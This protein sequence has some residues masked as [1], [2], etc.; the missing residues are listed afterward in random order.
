MATLRMYKLP[1]PAPTCCYR[2]YSGHAEPVAKSC[3]LSD[4]TAVSVGRGD[5]AII[6]WKVKADE[7][8]DATLSAMD[9]RNGSSAGFDWVSP[10]PLSEEDEEK[11]TQ[12]SMGNPRDVVDS[13]YAGGIHGFDAFRFERWWGAERLDAKDSE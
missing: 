9:F 12:L 1:V 5:G 6:Q 8:E 13:I 10:L 7:K 2:P 3:F 11:K 4:G